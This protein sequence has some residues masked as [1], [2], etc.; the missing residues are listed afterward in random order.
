MAAPALELTPA[1]AD[2][3]ARFAA[4]EQSADAAPFIIPYTLDDHRRKIAQPGMVYLRIL[5]EGALSGFFILALD[6]DAHSVEF[7]RI[8]VAEKGK[9]IGQAA[10]SVMERYCAREL[11]RLRIWLDVFEHNARGRHIYEKLGYRKFG[12][13]EHAGRKLLL[14]EKELPS[15]TRGTER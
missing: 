3:A 14:Y 12:E 8:V 2:D 15:E 5:R 1:T 13:S 4:M 10:I 7:R 9:G 11:G 6:S